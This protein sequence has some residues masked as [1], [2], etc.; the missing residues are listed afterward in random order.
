M[1]DYLVAQGMPF[2]Q[3]HSC[4]GKAVAYALNKKVELHELT[5]EEF[6]SFSSLFEKDIFDVL[7]I[8]EMINRRKSFGGTATE[9]VLTAI[10]EAEKELDDLMEG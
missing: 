1:A 10:K 4:V 8:E 9:N 3:A 6:K 2:R 7:T 5:L